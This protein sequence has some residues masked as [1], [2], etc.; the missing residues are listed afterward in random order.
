MS[1]DYKRFDDGPSG[2]ELNAPAYSRSPQQVGT[3][4]H[5]VVVNQ[6]QAVPPMGGINQTVII[7]QSGGKTWSTTLC[8]CTSDMESCCLVALCGPCYECWFHS[9]NNESCCT[10]ICVPG[11]TIALRTKIR[12]QHNIMGSIIDDCCVVCCCN[13]CALCQMKRE[14]DIIQR[15]QVVTTVTTSTMQDYQY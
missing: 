1:T 15:E 9:K 11:A 7:Q 4:P 3:S 14:Y 12:T 6:P 5:G 10:P 13:P 2:L 8:S